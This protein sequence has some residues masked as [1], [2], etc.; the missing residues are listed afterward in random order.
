MSRTY[1][2]PVV[3]SEDIRRG[4]VEGVYSLTQVEVH[5]LTQQS[6]RLLHMIAPTEDILR[7]CVNDD[8][9]FDIVDFTMPTSKGKIQKNIPQED[10]DAWVVEAVS[11]LRITDKG[12]FVDGVGFKISDRI[13]FIADRRSE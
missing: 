13:Y 4:Y 6:K 10:V 9:T 1:Y 5:D 3:T 8:G 7:V 11:M 2:Y 12:S